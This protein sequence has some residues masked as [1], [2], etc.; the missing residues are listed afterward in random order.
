M[1]ACPS[2][3]RRATL[4]LPLSALAF[5]L[6][7][8]TGTPANAA[9]AD[10]RPTLSA[11]PI[12]S[13]GTG[14]GT[15]TEELGIGEAEFDE[16]EALKAKAAKEGDWEQSKEDQIVVSQRIFAKTGNKVPFGT[17]AFDYTPEQI[18][19]LWPQ[20]MDGLRVPYPSPEYL[21]TR[22]DR[23]PAFR[24]SYPD[25]D[26][27]YEQYSRDVV[28]VWRLFFRGDYQQAMVEGGK[29][30][31]PSV[32]PGKVSQLI[33]AI[34]LEPN[35]EDKHQLLQDVSNT[36]REYGSSLDAMRKDKQFHAD[37]VIIRIGYAYA[38]G[39]IAEDVP[40]PVAIGRNYVFKV[41]DAANDVLDMQP[42]NPLGLAFRAGIDANVVRKVGKAT[43]RITFGAKQTDVSTYFDQA[44]K[45]VPNMAVIRYEH[46]NAMLYM[47]KKR[48]IEPAMEQL[49]LAAAAKPRFAME[50]LDAMYASK[51]LREVEALAKWP[52]SFRSFERKRL[53]HQKQS[54]QNL[55]CVMPKICP[56]FIIEQVLPP[57]RP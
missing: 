52:G 33:H 2:A 4:S 6:L 22:L 49:R 51:R 38:I 43:G 11:T 48:E 29:Y 15:N 13:T 56:P 28:N 32:I 12:S 55:Y 41:L 14:T 17:Q 21:K 10:A 31:I 19:E 1:A 53:K 35:L 47:N 27:D 54:N 44:L 20:L 18:K 50:A 42:N 40:I 8:T 7:I 30:G 23:F 3:F 46:A 26:G 25:F 39:R 45:T 5:T 57:V 9:S 34:Y 24:N 37:Y 16:I 36:V